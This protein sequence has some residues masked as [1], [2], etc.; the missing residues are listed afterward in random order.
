MKWVNSELPL[1]SKKLYNTN[2]KY[3]LIEQFKVIYKELL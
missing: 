1:M 3:K 2:Y